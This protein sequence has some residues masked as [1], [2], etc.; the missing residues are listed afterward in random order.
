MLEEERG[1][2]GIYSDHLETVTLV[3]GRSE[4]DKVTMQTNTSPAVVCFR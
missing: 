3:A 4:R 2:R 1:A